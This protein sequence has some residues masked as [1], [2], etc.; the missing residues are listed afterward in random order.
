MNASSNVG[1]YT[2]LYE[3]IFCLRHG[4]GEATEAERERRRAAASGCHTA[5]GVDRE[6][7]G[8]RA[9]AAA[10]TRGRTAPAQATAGELNYKLEDK[11]RL[12]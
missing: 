7:R 12:L 8:D 11:E 3:Y 4:L 5:A 1:E 2:S 9:Q 6:A 10:Q